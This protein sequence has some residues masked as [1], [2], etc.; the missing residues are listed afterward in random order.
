VAELHWAPFRKYFSLD[1]FVADLLRAG[2]RVTVAGQRIA[3]PAPDDLFLLLCAHGTKHFWCRLIWLVDVALLL[4]EHAAEAQHWLD[5]AQRKGMRRIVLVSAALVA[6]SLQLELPTAMADGVRQDGAVSHL[7]EA[8]EH[9]LYTGEAPADRLAENLLLL[10]IRERWRDV[11]L[12]TLGLAFH[13]G[14]QEWLN[15]PLPGWLA[16]LYPLVRAARAARYLPRLA[17]R[18]FALP[19]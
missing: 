17:R 15:F 16:W 4:R 11:V 8:M 3:V 5:L 7:I 12:I 14:P 18:V 2:V 9:S 13:P 6:R 10:R 19:K 1:F